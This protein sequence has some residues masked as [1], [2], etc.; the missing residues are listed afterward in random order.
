M[1]TLN[2]TQKRNIIIASSLFALVAAMVVQTTNAESLKS[3]AK[4]LGW[5]TA[6]IKVAQAKNTECRTENN[7]ELQATEDCINALRALEISF[8]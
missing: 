1:P 2:K 8:K 4:S 3:E 7:A 6:N 5:Y